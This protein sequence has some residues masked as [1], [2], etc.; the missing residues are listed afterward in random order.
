METFPYLLTRACSVYVEIQGSRI[1]RPSFVFHYRD[2]LLHYI[3]LISVTIKW[4]LRK[5]L[6]TVNL[7]HGWSAFFLPKYLMIL[8]GCI[9]VADNWKWF[10]SGGEM[11]QTCLNWRM[12]NCASNM[13]HL[14][15]Q[16]ESSLVP[17]TTWC[18][19]FSN[20]LS[21]EWGTQT[22]YQHTNKNAQP[23]LAQHKQRRRNWRQEYSKWG[24]LF[25]SENL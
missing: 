21:T 10:D 13:N 23:K 25:P 19:N 18:W 14:R 5:H 15:G 12:H 6:N 7:Q 3:E 20:S 24:V 11:H 17:H 4:R 2:H 22:T 1:S 16:P 9:G 8:T